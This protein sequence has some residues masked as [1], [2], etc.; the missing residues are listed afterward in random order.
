[1]ARILVADD[2]VGVRTF[3]ADALEVDGHTVVQAGDGVE[4]LARL[5]S[6]AST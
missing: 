6:R 3:I 5:A 4:A 1:M 2:E